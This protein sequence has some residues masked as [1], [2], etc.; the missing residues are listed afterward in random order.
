MSQIVK[1]FMGIFFLLMLSF[2]GIGIISAQLEVIQAQDYKADVIAELEN[3]NYSPSV[4]NACITQA[5]E[6]GYNIAVKLYKKGQEAILYTQPQVTETKEVQMAEVIVSY[7]YSIGFLNSFT[8]HQ[9]RGF[10]R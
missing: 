7:P 6:C 9:V 8:K 10:A 1:M 2:L 3:S 5:E 4:I